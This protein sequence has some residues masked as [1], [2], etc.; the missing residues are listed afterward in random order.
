MRVQEQMNEVGAESLPNQSQCIV[1]H[2]SVRMPADIIAELSL[3]AVFPVIVLGLHIQDVS[4]VANKWQQSWI[5]LTEAITVTT[6]MQ[7][8]HMH[9]FLKVLD[10]VTALFGFNH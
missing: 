3:L 9:N 5:Y 6:P 1:F 8:R 10:S 7:F 4:V 2:Q